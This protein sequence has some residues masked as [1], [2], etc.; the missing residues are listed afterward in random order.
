MINENNV[1]NQHTL[2]TTV[3]ITYP[4][5]CVVLKMDE[6]EIL[7]EKEGKRVPLRTDQTSIVQQIVYSCAHSTNNNN[8]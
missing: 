5:V 2:Y 1:K 7:C 6:L 3:L 8:N 4:Q